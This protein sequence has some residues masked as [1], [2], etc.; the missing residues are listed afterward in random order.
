[1]AHLFG[2]RHHGPGC[3]RSLLRAL[4]QLQPDCLLIE[5]PPDAADLHEANLSDVDGR[6]RLSRRGPIEPTHLR[7]QPFVIAGIFAEEERSKIGLDRGNERAAPIVR[8]TK[9]KSGRTVVGFELHKQHGERRRVCRLSPGHG[10]CDGA[11]Q[12]QPE[13]RRN[14]ALKLHKR[15]P[16][17]CSPLRKQ[18][19][20]LLALRAGGNE[21]DRAC[22]GRY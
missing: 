20:A 12:G 21:S 14:D 17:K 22:T 9:S 19:F 15:D 18:G 16:S 8:G 13:E 1:M 4:E 11:S 10:Q 6:I 5:G 7:G 3:A 2:I